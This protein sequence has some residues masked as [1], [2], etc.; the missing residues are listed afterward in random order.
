MSWLLRVNIGRESDFL[1]FCLFIVISSHLLAHFAFP[2]FPS[3][4][5]FL[6]FWDVLARF[7]IFFSFMLLTREA[8]R[9]FRCP[10]RSTNPISDLKISFGHPPANW[11]TSL[12]QY[13]MKIKLVFYLAHSWFLKR[14]ANQTEFFILLWGLWSPFLFSSLSLTSLW[15]VSCLFCI[16]AGDRVDRSRRV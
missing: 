15:P 12:C 6:L 14:F 9:I 1:C 2:N 13:P 4:W 7:P 16:A 11:D 8:V 5:L 3:D 10:L